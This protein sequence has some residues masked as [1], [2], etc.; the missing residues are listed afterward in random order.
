MD[1]DETVDTQEDWPNAWPEPVTLES[2]NA[3]LAGLKRQIDGLRDEYES[4]GAYVRDRATSDVEFIHELR[5]E[6]NNLLQLV[7]G[8]TLFGRY[9][10]DA[11]MHRRQAN[12]WR[13]HSVVILVAA[14]G[15]ETGLVLT[16]TAPTWITLVLPALPLALLF[17]YTSVESQNHRRA[18]FDRQR[19]FLRMAAIESYTTTDISSRARKKL[20]GLLNKFIERHFIEPELDSNDLSAV[21]AGGMGGWSARLRGRLAGGNRSSR[22]AGR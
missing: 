12:R 16:Q 19:I 7:R 17:T 21:V 8:R 22:S 6:A 13:R 14:V 20:G 2:L 1:P 4:A 10:D 3:E 9:A 18:E 11:A 15:L 5:D